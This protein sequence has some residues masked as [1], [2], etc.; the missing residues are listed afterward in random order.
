LPIFVKYFLFLVN[1]ASKRLI[2]STNVKDTLGQGKYST[3][4]GC[5]GTT[6]DGGVDVMMLMLMLMILMM[7]MVL[8][9]NFL[10]SFNNQN[11]KIAAI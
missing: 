7:L 10:F 5:G 4:Y 8:D 1:K 2:K 9:S 6:E 11:R 3:C